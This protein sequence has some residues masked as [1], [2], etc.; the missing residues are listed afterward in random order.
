MSANRTVGDDQRNRSRRAEPR[1]PPGLVG[2]VL[3]ECREAS[4]HRLA[5]V[6]DLV[7]E[8]R[9]ALAASVQN[10]VDDVRDV[11]FPGSKLGVL[12][13]RQLQV[14]DGLVA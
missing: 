8:A 7:A 11:A 10:A 4:V 14:G 3:L 12:A 1:Q 9:Q 13:G 5:L 6:L 2:D